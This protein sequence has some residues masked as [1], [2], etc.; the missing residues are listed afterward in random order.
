VLPLVP[1]YLTFVTGM[2]LDDVQRVRRATLVHALL[3]ILG[4]TIVF[5]LLGATATVVGRLLLQQRLWLTR[6]GGVLVMLFGLYLLGVLNVAPFSRER[7]L[8]LSDK[9][10][11][12]L[13]SV[14]VGIAFAAG[15]TP[16]IGPILGGILT[17]TATQ[18]DFAQG[19]GLLLTYALGL[20]VPFVLSA[21]AVE[22]LIELTR[23]YSRHLIWVS[24]V[25]GVLVLA[26]GVLMVTGYLPLLTGVLQGVTP[27]FLRE[28]L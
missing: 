10:L 6:V 17:Y 20:A 3:F 7:R 27:S 23:A 9:P 28:R 1:S 22:R 15:W 2:S 18:A 16:C 5:V 13:G 14:L 26:L 21:I 8:H 24:R 12:Y 25:S 11:G 19:I 4:F